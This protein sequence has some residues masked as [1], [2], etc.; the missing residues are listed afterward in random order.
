[1]S[2]ENVE[3]VRRSFKAWNENDWAALEELY[4][5]DAVAIAPDGWPESGPLTGFEEISAMFARTKDSW[6][7]EHVEIDSL[8][9]I[10]PDKVFAQIRWVTKGR[11][12]GIPFETPMAELLTVRGGRIASVEFYLDQAAALEAAGLSE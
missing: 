1:M 6:D 8:R 9:D 10:G 7:E 5:P 2:Q 3:A 11:G 4:Q 12:S